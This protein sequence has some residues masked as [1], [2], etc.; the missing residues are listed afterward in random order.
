MVT[1]ARISGEPTQRGT[2]KGEDGVELGGDEILLSHDTSSQDLAAFHAL[3]A[4]VEL[5]VRCC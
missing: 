2:K 1:T 4:G 5:Y 3:Q